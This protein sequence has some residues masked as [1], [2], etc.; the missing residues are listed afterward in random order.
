MQ[1]TVNHRYTHIH[2]DAKKKTEILLE[3]IMVK[4]C[5]LINN[6]ACNS[7]TIYSPINGLRVPNDWHGWQRG[8]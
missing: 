2:N 1:S 3:F 6:S 8:A 5:N 4:S 7:Q